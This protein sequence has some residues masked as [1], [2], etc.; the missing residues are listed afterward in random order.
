[1]NQ[2]L[3]KKGVDK[4]NPLCYNK[5]TKKKG[6]KIMEKDICPNCGKKE[7]EKIQLPLDLAWLEIP[8]YEDWGCAHCG[9]SFFKKIEIGT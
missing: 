6:K 2:K 4:L 8:G 7:L 3:C 5:D 9:Q 1:V